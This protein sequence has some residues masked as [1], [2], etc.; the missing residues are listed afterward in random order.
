[1]KL[2]KIE[3]IARIKIYLGIW[4]NV[5]G[6][7]CIFHVIIPAHYILTKIFLVK[8]KNLGTLARLKLNYGA[9]IQKP[10]M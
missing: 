7:G 5:G 1:M 6:K 10:K 3:K 4:W 8:L 9:T 2:L